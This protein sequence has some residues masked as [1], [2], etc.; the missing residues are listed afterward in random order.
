MLAPVSYASGSLRFQRHRIGTLFGRTY[1]LAAVLAGAAVVLVAGFLVSQKFLTTFER[2]EIDE[3]TADVS[4]YVVPVLAHHLASIDLDRELPA[5][6][7]SEIITHVLGDGPRRVRGLQVWNRWGTIVLASDPVRLDLPSEVFEAALAG[8]SSGR[9]IRRPGSEPVLEVYSPLRVDSQGDVVGVV[10]ART[11]AANLVR[12]LGEVRRILYLTLAGG[13]GAAYLAMVGVV[14]LGQRAINRRDRA[15][16]ARTRD[17]AAARHETVLAIVSALDLRDAETE[18]HS[19]RVQA[20]AVDIARRAGCPD[21]DI[22]VIELGALVHD[23]GKIG[24]PDHILRKPG[25]LS[26]D[27][28]EQMRRHP[29]LGYQFL[30]GLSQFRA[31]A[32]IVYAH[33][34]RYDGGGYPRGLAGDAIPLGAR[35]FAVADAY[36]AM[37]SDRPYRRARSHE[38]A[39]D[40]IARCSGSQ[41]DPAVVDAFLELVESW[42][43]LRALPRAA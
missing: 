19:L 18:G 15:L 23:I 32:D 5:A 24:V 14:W 9:L 38:E 12:E 43:G 28:W 35:I 6:D 16:L 33:H 31:A 1:L 29:E 8:T 41:F 11:S 27:E 4:A 10:G 39:V 40:E 2:E 36:D 17:L 25:P 26:P 20:L 22:D 30:N 13:L 21:E 3:K 34:E 42:P 37:T 7:Q